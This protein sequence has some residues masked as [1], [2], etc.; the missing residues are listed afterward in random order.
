MA[1]RSGQKGGTK[2]P[3]FFIPASYKGNQRISPKLSTPV[4]S[5]SGQTATPKITI[6]PTGSDTAKNR[7]GK[8]NDN[9]PNGKNV[10]NKQDRLSDRSPSQPKK[11]S[12]KSP[13]LYASPSGVLDLSLYDFAPTEN[14]S[15]PKAPEKST[16]NEVPVQPYETDISGAI[17]KVDDESAVVIKP[18]KHRRFRRPRR[19]SKLDKL[20][21]FLEDKRV[22]DDANGD[23]LADLQMPRLRKVL[24]I[25]FV[26]LGVCF[27]LAVITVILYTTI[28][29]RSSEQFVF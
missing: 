10:P 26:T 29:T 20:I 1:D 12:N 9:E 5:T 27:L 23:E 18:K 3:Q 2:A 13:Y 8:L 11:D 15:Q 24:N 4:V 6:S 21:K 14:K 7:A 17:T 16:A 22:Q 25:I 28:A 19:N